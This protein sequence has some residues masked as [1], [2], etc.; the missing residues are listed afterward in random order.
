[1]NST[2]KILIG[3]GVILVLAGIVVL[4]VGR[5]PGFKSMPGDIVIKKENFTLYFPLG[6]SILLS[7]LLTLA[8]FLWRKFGG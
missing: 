1:M 3:L 4:L 6:T 8:I 2:G 7:L 5:F